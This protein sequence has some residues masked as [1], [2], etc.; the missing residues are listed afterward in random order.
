[1]SK[2]WLSE[3]AQKQMCEQTK[4]ATKID[5]PA[6]AF[7]DAEKREQRQIKLKLKLAKVKARETAKN[8]DVELVEHLN[9]LRDVE[10]N[11]TAVEA[12]KMQGRSAYEQR[13][14]KSAERLCKLQRELEETNMK[15]QKALRD[16][17]KTRAGVP[18]SVSGLQGLHRRRESKVRALRNAFQ[19]SEEAWKA[20]HLTS[21]AKGKRNSGLR[22]AV[23][24]IIS[25]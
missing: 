6:K 25:S 8:S 15:M 13:C 12:Q 1:M 22:R 23:K 5:D 2:L 7:R 21:S 11:I 20:E 3:K 10:A 4:K 24:N 18:E 14:T 9:A 19:I 16:L 17:E